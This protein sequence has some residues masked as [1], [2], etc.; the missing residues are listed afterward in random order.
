[1]HPPPTPT[2]IEVAPPPTVPQVVKPLPGYVLTL[3]L[4][5]GVVSPAWGFTGFLTRDNWTQWAFQL[6]QARVIVAAIA[7]LA[8]LPIVRAVLGCFVLDL[9]R[10]IRVVGHCVLLCGA[11]CCFWTRGFSGRRARPRFLRRS[12]HRP[13]WGL[14]TTRSL[15]GVCRRRVGASCR[16]IPPV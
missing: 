1:M 14:C 7:V 16:A 5:F 2:P 10:R 15:P 4:L 13:R 6:S 9:V 11:G 8:F 3:F 12:P